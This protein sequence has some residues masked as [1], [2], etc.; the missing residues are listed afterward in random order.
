MN[1]APLFVVFLIISV[2]LLMLF[3][4]ANGSIYPWVTKQ[5]I[6]VIIG[7]I[8]LVCIVSTDLHWWY[9]QSYKIYFLVL[10]LLIMVEIMGFIGMGAQRWLNLY[11][12]NL[13]PSELMRIA[14]VL[15]L[16]RYFSGL[17]PYEVSQFRYLV[18]PLM[19]VFIPVALVLKQ[20][21]LG[22]AVL[23]V[24]GALVVFFIAGVN[25]WFFIGGIVSALIS[26]PILWNFLHGYQKKRVLI[27]LNPEIDPSHAGYHITQS[28]IALGSGG[29]FGKG[30][31]KGTQSHLNFLPEKQTDFIFTMLAEEFG[32]VGCASLLVLFGF[33]ISWGYF[34]AEHSKSQYGRMVAIGLISTLFLYVFINSA[35]V[36]GLL[37]VVGVPMPFLSYGGTSMVTMMAS[38]AFIFCVSIPRIGKK[39]G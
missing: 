15:A 37:P 21:D 13:Q 18:F 12:I 39:F 28:K 3:S 9:A 22:T 5:I 11:V 1:F 36:M 20:P 25:K 6:N 16:A 2:G 19:L 27:F 38:V 33:L 8:I 35:M 14:L 17:T 34:V 4:A 29:F 26:M 30:W 7:L 23:L 32:F 10:I 24:S 31:L